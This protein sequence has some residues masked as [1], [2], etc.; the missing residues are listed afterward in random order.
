MKKTVSVVDQLMVKQREMMAHELDQYY[1]N[2]GL[3]VE[4]ELSGPGKTFINLSSPL[5]CRD[6]VNR[7]VKT[8]NLFVYLKEA[9]FRKATIEGSNEEVWAYDLKSL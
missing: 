5:F 4:V 7:I 1:T 6:T 3:S 2:K 8:T 9:G